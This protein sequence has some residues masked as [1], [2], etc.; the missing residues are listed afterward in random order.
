[1]VLPKSSCMQI[2]HE[3]SNIIGEKV[4]M[5]DSDGIIIAST[6][7]ERIGTFHG[8][9]KRIIDEKLPNLAIHSNEEFVG[10]RQGINLPVELRGDIVG[11]IGVTGPADAVS[12]YGEIIKK[13]TEILLLDLTMHEEMDIEER[14]RTR[15]LNDWIHADSKE[16]DRQMVQN[17]R[18]LGIDIMLP[19]RVMM[20]S[21]TPR[22]S[23]LSPALQR[24]IDE[25]ESRILRRVGGMKNA[26]VFKSGSFIIACVNMAEDAQLLATA[27][28]VKSE[29]EGDFAGLN[30]CIGIDMAVPSMLF[31]SSAYQRARKALRTCL[32][33]PNKEARLYDSINMEIFSSEIPDAIKLEYVRRIF[34]GCTDEEIGDYVRLLNTY[35]NCEGSA[36]MA[37]EKLYIHKNT[38]QYR[39]KQLREKTGYDPRS[40]RFSSL[41]Y[42]ALHFYADVRDLMKKSTEESEDAQNSY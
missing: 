4:N 14:I 35:Y 38:L 2:V 1:M 37:A 18:D 36:A 16:I 3:I 28:A 41:F 21:V 27:N 33:S 24:G 42:N 10:S 8:G 22:D 31:I 7:P 13:M 29:V 30:C 5:M 26:I 9:A 25:A 40:I 11:V 15:F 34:R 39:L 20:L 23:V 19:R 6:D 17:G 12:K 32:R